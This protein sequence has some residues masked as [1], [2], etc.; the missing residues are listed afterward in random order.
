MIRGYHPGA[1]A[2]RLLRDLAAQVGLRHALGRPAD[3]AAYA[4]DAFGASGERRLPDA[5]VFPADAEEVAAVLRTCA[6][7]RVPVIPRGAGTGYSGGAVPAAQPAGGVVLNLA[8]LNRVLGVEAEAMR[9]QVEAGVVTA[10]VHR[11]ATEARLYYPPDPG[12]ATTSTIGGNVVCNAAGAHALRYGTTADF[13]LGATVVLAD[14]RILRVG[15]GGDDGDDLLR[16]LPASEGTLA[17][18]TDVL[19]R[20]IAAPQTR[21]T[22]GATF[23]GMQGAADAAAAISAAGL[24][25]AALEV[26]DGA[27]LDAIARSLADPVAPG[28][29]AL[30]IAD[31]EGDATGVNAELDALRSA[32]EGAGATTVHVA[33]DAAEAARLWAARRAISAAVARVMIGKVN[34]DVVVPRD[35]VAECV[36]AARLAGEAEQVPVVTFGHLGDG[37]LHCTFLIDPRLPGERA[38]GD[39]AARRLFGAVL[40]M[41]GSLTGEHGVGQVKVGY[42]EEQLGAGTLAL[43]GRLKAALD[44]AGRLNPGKK[45]AAALP[46]A[47]RDVPVAATRH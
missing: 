9:I 15:E 1:M 27:A 44:P 33:G 22:V 11:R 42:L 47:A 37:N 2:D 21:A 43:M 34:E 24:V 14:G 41:G 17:V 31:L 29:G 4:Y 6:H 35:R 26:L 18:I 3:L 16:L 36:E 28:A 7:H 32:L 12:S 30:V 40:A 38:R 8:R 46:I 10:T 45:L 39:A 19:L 25:P 23:T 5:I 20:A 13:L